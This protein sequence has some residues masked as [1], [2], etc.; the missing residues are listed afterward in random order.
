MLASQ[1]INDDIPP[2][3]VEDT[4]EKA[5]RWMDEFRVSHLPVING[6]EFIGLISDDDLYDLDD[7]DAPIGSHKLSLIKPVLHPQ[8]HAYDVLKLMA[9]LGL[10]VLAVT[11]EHGTYLGSVTLPRLAEKLSR[12]AAVREP[13]GI[14]VLEVNNVDY[15]LAQIAQIVEGNDAKILSCYVAGIPE[16]TKVEVTLKVNRDDLSRIVQTFN[17]Y[18]YTVKATFHQSAYEEDLRKRYDEFMNYISM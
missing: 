13:G 12:L 8:Q 14:L 4:A 1:L 6:K 7:P 9:E 3:K 18:N 11:D 17:R 2:L 16:S 5:L 10:E 15:S